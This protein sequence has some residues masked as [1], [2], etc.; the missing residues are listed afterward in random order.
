MQ[1]K[2]LPNSAP[3][4]DLK[5]SEQVGIEGIYC[6]IIKAVCE[7]LTGNII[8]NREKLKAFCL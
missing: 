6:N 4:H 7:K 1:K 8:P 2:T 3:F 5:N